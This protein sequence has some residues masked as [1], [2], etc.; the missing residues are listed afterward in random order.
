MKI[1]VIGGSGRIGSKLVKN[2]R[3]RGYE[4]FVRARYFGL[5]LNDQ[6]L[7]PGDHPRIDPTRFDAWLK[8]YKS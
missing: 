5:E 8:Q 2:L 6:S 7:M 3:Q 1:V 4:V